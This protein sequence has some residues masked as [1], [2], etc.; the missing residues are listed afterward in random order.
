MPAPAATTTAPGALAPV[1]AC[2]AGRL[3]YVEDNPVNL[4][5]VREL[6][7]LRPTL[8]LAEATDGASGVALARGH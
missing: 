4:L 3:L 8:T 2:R 1:R 5:L 6:V 7:A